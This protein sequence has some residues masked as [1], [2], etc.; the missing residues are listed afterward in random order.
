M[1]ALAQARRATIFGGKLF[2]KGFC[3]MLVPTEHVGNLVIWHMLFN[4]DGS[5]ISYAD[6]RI[7]KILSEHPENLGVSDLESARHILGWCSNVKNY[8]GRY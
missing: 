8:T 2:V 7:H 6:P 4:E 1:A 5:H 3:T